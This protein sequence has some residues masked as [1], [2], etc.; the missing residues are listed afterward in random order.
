MICSSRTSFL[1]IRS[2]YVKL[3]GFVYDV[4][5]LS[6]VVFAGFADVEVGRGD[7]DCGCGCNG[8]W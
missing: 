3:D 7:D 4:G 5:S 1:C 8:F 2:S 6:C